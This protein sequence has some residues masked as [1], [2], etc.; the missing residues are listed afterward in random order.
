M[1]YESVRDT[2]EVL[3][4]ARRLVGVGLATAAVLLTAA[5][6]QGSPPASAGPQRRCGTFEFIGVA[7][8][9]E[10]DHADQRTQ[11]LG[12]GKTVHELY[13]Q[14]S[15]LYAASQTS[16]VPYGVA[17]PALGPLAWLPPHNLSRYFDSRDQGVATLTAELH[18]A[19]DACPAEQFILAGYSQGADVITQTMLTLNAELTA[20]VRA[21]ILFGEPEFNPKNTA[22]NVYDATH[23]GI[24]GARPV[25]SANL[26]ERTRSFCLPQDLICQGPGL[27]NSLG[28]HFRYAKDVTPTA[29]AYLLSIEP[30]MRCT[31]SAAVWRP[32]Y[33]VYSQAG[34]QLFNTQFYPVAGAMPGY[35][36]AGFVAAVRDPL[37]TRIDQPSYTT[38]N[39]GQNV[40]TSAPIYYA[41]ARSVPASCGSRSN[42]A[43]RVP[44]ATQHR[45]EVT[46]RVTSGGMPVAHATIEWLVAPAGTDDYIEVETASDATDNQGNFHINAVDKTK[47]ILVAG[48]YKMRVVYPGDINRMSGGSSAINVT[49]RT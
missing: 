36:F 20:R 45:I 11:S 18:A 23:H 7:G 47:A 32:D 21:D 42:V 40:V 39:H 5:I 27:A 44:V 38:E 41:L 22:E 17:Y 30:P 15:H 12:M 33:E 31:V 8:S 24:I 4:R 19:G 9:G 46:G 2:E 14:V 49:V 48:N 16:L 3:V 25:D 43:L 37:P 10:L 34:T 35:R 1:T 28:V 13:G 29:A 6:V 26:Q